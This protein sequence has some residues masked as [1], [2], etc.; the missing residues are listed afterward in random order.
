MN[1]PSDFLSVNSS[2]HLEIEKADAVR[3]A[4]DYGTPLYVL[5]HGKIMSNLNDQ[6]GRAHV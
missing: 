2:G 1:K 3:I 5:S 4:S 6:I